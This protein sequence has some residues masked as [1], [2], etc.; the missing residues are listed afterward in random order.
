MTYTY[1]G[2]KKNEPTI[3]KPGDVSPKGHPLSPCGTP[4]GYYRHVKANE[5][6]CTR[7]RT[8]CNNQ[9]RI[10]DGYKARRRAVAACGTISG[11]QAHRRRKEPAC[12]AC[13]TALREYQR[14]HFGYGPQKKA[15]LHGTVAGYSRHIRAKQPACL[16]CLKGKREYDKA[17]KAKKR[18]NAA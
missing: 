1:R 14:E 6:A 17:Y 12:D 3:V 18:A 2:H 7:C 15:P 13:L 8:A 16:A 10:R 4:A 5:Y 9:R 11:Y